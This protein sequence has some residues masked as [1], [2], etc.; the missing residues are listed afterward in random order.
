MSIRR[1]IKDHLI[2]VVIFVGVAIFAWL[3]LAIMSVPN[4]GILFVTL[5]Y[6]FAFLAMSVIDYLIRYSFYKEVKENLVGLDKKYLLPAVITEPAF[7]EGKVLYD[8]IKEADKSMNDEVVKYQVS[9][10]EYREFIELWIHE[11]KTPIASSKLIIENHPSAITK[12]L[13]EEMDSIE[14]FLEQALFYSRSNS[15]EKDYIIKRISLKTMVFSVMRKNAKEFIQQKIAHEMQNLDVVVQTDEK[16]TEYIIGQVV[17][18]A[19]KYRKKNALIKFYAVEREQAVNLV[20]EDNGIGIAKKDVIKVF[21]KSF[22]GGIGRK[23]TN[24]T[25]L[26]L[27]LSKKLCNKMGMSIT[28]E[29]EEGIG[30]KVTIVF[31]KGAHANVTRM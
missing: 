31:P 20:I 4:E 9:A 23:Y 16:W 30:T 15:L 12:S 3:Q 25:G 24:A 8:C 29:S 6:M 21:E 17:N 14:R 28:L 13:G 7:C 1:Y 27:Y 26:G 18:N 22:T 11:V 19:I 5:L 10:E 2:M